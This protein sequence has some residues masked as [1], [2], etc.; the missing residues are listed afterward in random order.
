[1]SEFYYTKSHFEESR[2]KQLTRG[3]MHAVFNEV[4]QRVPEINRKKICASY[5]P[6]KNIAY[7]WNPQTG[8][9]VRL[10]VYICECVVL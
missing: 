5:I 3:V 6:V 2:I 10:I 1:M 7:E 9:E 4:M 8:E